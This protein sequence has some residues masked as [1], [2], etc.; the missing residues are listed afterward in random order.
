MFSGV[1]GVLCYIGFQPPKT[2]TLFPAAIVL[3]LAFDSIA[4][5][6]RDSVNMF[7]PGNCLSWFG[8]VV[9]SSA[10]GGSAS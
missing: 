7:V 5:E 1:S 3:G 6:R 8:Q 4:L 2:L 9:S 10:V